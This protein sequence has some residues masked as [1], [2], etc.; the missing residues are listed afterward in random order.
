MKDSETTKD[1][2]VTKATD[3]YLRTVTI[4]E[5][6]PHNSTIHLAPYDPN[7]PVLFERLA[8]RIRNALSGKVILL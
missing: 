2:G 6:K 5:R 4:G 3:E 7:W 8:S 1:S